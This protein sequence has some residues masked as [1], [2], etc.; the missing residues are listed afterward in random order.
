MS[1]VMVVKSLKYLCKVVSSLCIAIRSED[2][3]DE[4]WM[5]QKKKKMKKVINANELLP[6]FL[7]LCVCFVLNSWFFLNHSGL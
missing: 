2:G 4:D 7:R 6:V 5:K 3:G 1:L